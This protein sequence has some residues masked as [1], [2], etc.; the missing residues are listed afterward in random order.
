MSTEKKMHNLKA[1]N[2]VLFGGLTEDYNLGYKIS[3]SSEGLFRRGKGGTERK[4]TC[5]QTSRITTNHKNRHLKLMIFVL[6]YAW[7]NARVWAY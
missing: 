3:E 6:F 7:E 2:Y 1:E 5:S 4:N